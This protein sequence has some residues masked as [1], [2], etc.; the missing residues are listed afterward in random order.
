MNFD[1]DF[2]I[3]GE[4]GRDG[5]PGSPGSTGIQGVRGPQGVQGRFLPE[6]VVVRKVLI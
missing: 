6:S 2:D 5:I 4:P 3:A 1:G